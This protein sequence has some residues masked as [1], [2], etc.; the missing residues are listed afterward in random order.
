M[1]LAAVLPDETNPSG[2][3]YLHSTISLSTGNAGFAFTTYSFLKA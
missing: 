3:N 2:N 1:G